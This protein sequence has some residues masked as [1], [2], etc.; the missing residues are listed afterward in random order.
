MTAKIKLNAA[1]G[2]GSFSLQAPSSSANN[3]VMTLPDSA[4]G[5]VLT[6]TNPKAG[7][8]IQVVQ[9]S[10][11]SEVSSTS[12]N[13]VDSGLSA[14]ITPSNANNKILITVSQ[15]YRHTRASS[16]AGGGFQLL[17]GSTIIENGPNNASGSAPFGQYI[18][19]DGA[20]NIEIFG[21]YCIEYLD[22][23]NTTSSTAYKTKMSLH[24]T[25]SSATVRAQ[26]QAGG[27][28]GTSYMT[29][30]EVAV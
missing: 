19:V 24:T 28:N 13:Y 26:Y 27:E 1:S 14:S 10:T 17:R 5:T 23:P 12:S 7:N 3:R 16:Q 9:A 22:S 11:S 20:S 25:A 30:M 4:D 8:I 6:T 18:V 29:L 21:R 15:Y 2:G